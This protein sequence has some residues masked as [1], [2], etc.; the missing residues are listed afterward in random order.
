MS[1]RQF[2]TALMFIR[3]IFIP[4]TELNFLQ[5]FPVERQ[6]R[7]VTRS[8]KIKSL[9]LATH[10]IAAKSFTLKILPLTPLNGRF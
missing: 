3:H 8:L 4:G 10:F 5:S 9:V 6:S 7:R 2:S 1:N